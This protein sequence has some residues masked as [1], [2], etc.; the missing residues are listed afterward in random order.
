MLYVGPSGVG[1]LLISVRDILKDKHG[2][3]V[4]VESSLENLDHAQNALESVGWEDE[5][6]LH[7][8]DIT[9]LHLIDRLHGLEKPGSNNLR[10]HPCLKRS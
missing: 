8:G 1:Q 2:K 5:I 3:I 4:G 7:L 10:C 9:G 6:T